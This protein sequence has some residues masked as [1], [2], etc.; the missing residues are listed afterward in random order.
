MSLAATA[1]SD[2]P[3]SSQDG[4]ETNSGRTPP[5]PKRIII[6]ASYPVAQPEPR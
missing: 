4:P 2:A 3:L 6:A 1:I 5:P